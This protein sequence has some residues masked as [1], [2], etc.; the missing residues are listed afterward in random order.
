MITFQGIDSLW[1][2]PVFF[3][4]EFLFLFTL[5]FNPQ[6]YLLVFDLIILI[7]LVLWSNVAPFRWPFA[8]INKALMG[9]L[10]FS[11]G[12]LVSNF[13]KEV[14][15]RSYTFL[16]LPLC[17]LGLLGS[18]YNG[19]SSFANLNSPLLF[20]LNGLL[21][22]IVLLAVCN[23]YYI[24]GS[25]YSKVLTFFGRETLFVLCTNNLIIESVRLFDHKVFSSFMLN[26]GWLGYILMFVVITIIEVL[27]ILSYRS[28]RRYLC[29][30]IKA[31]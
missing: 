29:L 28:L 11:S 24:S 16:F 12:Y 17:I 4:S 2:L 13:Y 1:F 30:S 8:L 5:K 22:S 10:F 18:Y 14:F 9:Y 20:Y 26:S 6:K 21:L 19:F 7:T 15:K 31:S 23:Y 3:L 25:G 27:F